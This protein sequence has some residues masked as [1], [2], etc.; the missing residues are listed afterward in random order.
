MRERHALPR[1]QS[2]HTRAHTHAHR[3]AHAILVPPASARVGPTHVSASC[4]A[5]RELACCTARTAACGAATAGAAPLA[6]PAP[7][8]DKPPGTLGDEAGACVEERPC[9]LAPAPATPVDRN[10]GTAGDAIV[11]WASLAVERSSA[12]TEALTATHTHTS[13]TIS[14]TNRMVTAMTRGNG[15]CAA[16]RTSRAATGAGRKS[17]SRTLNRDNKWKL[18]DIERPG[19][20]G[21]GTMPSL[22]SSNPASWSS[23]KDG[24]RALVFTQQYRWWPFTADQLV[25]N[26][27]CTRQPTKA[28]RTP[29]SSGWRTH[30]S[31][32]GPPCATA[33]HAATATHRLA[34]V[35]TYLL[36]R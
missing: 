27:S 5:T 20:S 26:W 15:R 18:H 34:E 22:L 31:G 4:R 6:P 36:E 28:Q 3:N 13:N 32:T 29:T 23:V 8:A 33:P 7:A 2:A 35:G 25:A 10:C 17:G 14:S 24:F 21:G 30:N 11:L 19:Y 1:P 9:A 16:T 12:E